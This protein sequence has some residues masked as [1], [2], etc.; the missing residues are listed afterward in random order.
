MNEVSIEFVQGDSYCNVYCSVLKYVNKLKKL[1]ELYPQQIK[2]VGMNNDDDNYIQAK[3]PIEW[4]KFVGPPKSLTLTE[5]DRQKR[6]ER[7]KK[8]RLN[9]NNK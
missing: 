6:A 2:I 1:Q 9:K 3:V 5:E 7:L 4:F 8:A